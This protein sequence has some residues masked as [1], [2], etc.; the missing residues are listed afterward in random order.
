MATKATVSAK[1]L[2]QAAA[3]IERDAAQSLPA[4]L[5]LRQTDRHEQDIEKARVLRRAAEIK[6]IAARRDYLREHGVE[7]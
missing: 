6:S 1:W 5:V 2:L 3:Q 7:A 4:R